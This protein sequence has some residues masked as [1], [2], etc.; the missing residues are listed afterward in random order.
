LGIPCGVLINRAG[1]GDGKVEEYC[2]TQNI[3]VL[4]TIP[5]DAQI[6]SFYS[7]GVPLVNGIPEWRGRFV[8]L[9]GEIK[10]KATI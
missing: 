10:Q 2:G 1:I 9:F 4:L 7:R 6:A 8:N 3:P 5:L